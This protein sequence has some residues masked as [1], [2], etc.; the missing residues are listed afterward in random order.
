MHHQRSD[1]IMNGCEL[2][3]PRKLR[4][5]FWGMRGDVTMVPLRAVAREHKI[6]GV[7]TANPVVR[8]DQKKRIARCGV[9]TLGDYAD[10]ENIPC[11][12]IDHPGKEEFLDRLRAIDADIYCISSFNQ[13]LSKEMMSIPP[14][15]VI[16]RHDSY[17][18]QYRGPNPYFWHFY[19]QKSESGVTVHRIDE[20]EDTG[21]ILLQ[22]SF[23][24][25]F[26]MTG[27]EFLRELKTIGARLLVDALNGLRDGTI[28]ERVN[29]VESPT[30]RASRLKKGK[31]YVRWH[32]WSSA[33]VYAFLQGVMPIWH[34][35]DLLRRVWIEFYDLADYS[36]DS[37]VP[38][39]KIKYTR[40]GLLVGCGSGYIVFSR[41]PIRY[42]I[43]RLPRNIASRVRRF[44][45]KSNQFSMRLFYSLSKKLHK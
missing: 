6:V 38:S 11:L 40:D 9:E 14:L 10:S 13:L 37:G 28:E 23:P 35:P 18:P 20:G 42:I 34:T 3:A 7:V 26:G 1:S 31:E 39:G 30:R 12:T 33:R 15:G 2:T 29:P 22:Q 45:S 43:L 41:K 36:E 21:N 5:V 19:D 8:K 32:E 25:P 24:M 16:N 4:V 17:L 44:V 27:Y